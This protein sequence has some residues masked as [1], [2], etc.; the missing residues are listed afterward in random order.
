M[1][2]EKSKQK[3]TSDQNWLL[4][5]RLNRLAHLLLIVLIAIYF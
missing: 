2:G 4:R 1:K 3:R 5:P